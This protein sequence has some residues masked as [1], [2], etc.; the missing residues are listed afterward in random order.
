LAH[1]DFARLAL[2]HLEALYR[3]A[4]RLSARAA[5]AEDLVQQTYLEGQR[6][7]DTLKDPGRCRAWLFRILRN[8]SHQRRLRER[9]RA[10]AARPELPTAG[11]LEA[12]L[13]GKSYSDE[14]ERALR[15]LPEE[16]RSALLLVAVEELS[17]EEVAQAMDC[18][19]GTVRSRV[20]RGRALLA[21]E[22][23]AAR[24]PSA[25]KESG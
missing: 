8:L 12:E 1:A 5:E 7:F 25:R 16:L 19:L 10:A 14:V 21:A 15:A 23:A 20:A 3:T 2:P 11:D 4:C 22:L 13:V 17:Y 18:P 6:C 24:A 9:V